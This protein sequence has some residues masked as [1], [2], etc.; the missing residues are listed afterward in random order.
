MD[1]L[2]SNRSNFAQVELKFAFRKRLLG[3]KWVTAW[4]QARFNCYFSFV[5]CFFWQQKC[6]FCITNY[7]WDSKLVQY[8]IKKNVTKYILHVGA[9]V[10]IDSRNMI[11][12]LNVVRR[13][14]Q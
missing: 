12:N 4:F 1:K 9:I 6:L 5:H 13:A 7:S 10:N 11:K 3:C 14:K 8:C 2:A